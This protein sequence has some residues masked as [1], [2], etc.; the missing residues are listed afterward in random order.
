MKPA[1]SLF[2]FLLSLATSVVFG[3]APAIQL[4]ESAA[5]RVPENKATAGSRAAR[6]SERVVAEKL[7]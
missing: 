2:T 3:L 5:G 1:T 7:A 4:V 6:A